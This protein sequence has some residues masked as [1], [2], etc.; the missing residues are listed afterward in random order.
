MMA[1]EVHVLI[2]DDEANTRGELALILG[3][4][5]YK[6]ETARTARTALEKARGRFFH[7]ALIESRLLDLIAPLQVMR[8]ETVVIVTA[9]NDSVETEVRALN[10]GATAVITKP[11]HKDQVLAII[12]KALEKQRLIME[13]RQLLA[14]VGPEQ[15]KR[16]ETADTLLASDERSRRLAEAAH[17]HMG[18][19]IEGSTFPIEVH[20]KANP[21]K[22]GFVRLTAV[23]DITERMQA[24]ARLRKLSRAVE[25]SPSAVL[26]YD[27]GGVIEYVNPRFV[28]MTGYLPEE[29]IGTHV[30]KLGDNTAEEKKIWETILA[31]GEWQGEILNRKKDGDSYWF[32]ASISSIRD[33]QGVI[34]HF[35]EVQ[36]DITERRKTEEAM[37]QRNRELSLLNRVIAAAASTLEPEAVLKTTCRELAKTFDVPQS[38]AA[39]LDETGTVLR[40]VAEY[41]AEDGPTSLGA[42]IP[43]AGN[44]ATQYVLEQKVP[45]AVADAQQDPRMAPVHELMRR[46]GVVSILLIPLIVGD[47]VAGTVGLDAME[48]REFT[49][50]EIDL[51][52]SAVTTAAQMLEKAQLLTA[53]KRNAKRLTDILGL[54][55]DLAMLRDESELLKTLV[56]RVAAFTES[57]TCTILLLDEF[58]NEAVLMAQAGLPEDTPPT[59]RISL[60]LPILSRSLET[61]EPII[62]SDID[63][64]APEM[65]AVLVHP[66]I[67]AFFAYPMVKEGRTVGFMTLSDLK[68]RTPSE[69][70][71][72]AFRLLSERAAAALE[73]V[74]L[75]T[76]LQQQNLDLNRLHLASGALFSGTMSGIETLAQEIVETIQREFEHSNCSL[77]I[78]FEEGTAELRRVAAVGP[79]AAQLS[80]WSFPL[81]GKGLIPAAVRA[82]AI[83]NV[84][85]VE[86]H[87]DYTQGWQ[88]TRSEL[89]IPLIIG[90]RVIGAIDL[91]SALPAN[92]DLADER[93]LADFAERAA[94]ALQTANF[95]VE[96]QRRTEELETLREASLQL[97]SSLDRQEVMTSIL[98]NAVHLATAKNAYVFLYDEQ[99]LSFGAAYWMDGEDRQ[100]VYTEPRSDGVTETVARTGKPLV[101]PDVNSHPLFKDWQWGGAIIGLPLIMGGQILGVMNVAFSNPRAIEE[102]ELRILDLL[103]AQAAI[104]LNNSRLFD[105]IRRRAEE[106]EAV[107][108]VSSALR[109]A[110]TQSD[111]VPIILDEVSDLLNAESIALTI[112]DVISGES[113]I[114]LS[115]GAWDDINTLG[116]CKGHSNSGQVLGSE[117][118]LSTYETTLDSPSGA[119]CVPLIAQEI[120]IGDLWIGRGEGITKRE[121]Q[122]VAAIADIAASAIQRTRLYEKTLRHAG[123]LERRV[124]ERTNALSVAN[125]ELT[126]ANRAKDEFL[127]NMSHELRTPLSN[128]LVRSD[129]LQKGIY[130]PLTDKQERSLYVIEESSR[131]LLQLINDILDVSK[132]EAGKLELDVHR[133][134]VIS[135]CESSL[136]FVKEMAAQ[137]GIQVHKDIQPLAVRADGRR[138]KQILVNLLSNAVKF[139]PEGG[140]IG[141]EVYG[142]ADMEMIQFAVWDT[143][144]GIASDDIARLFQPFSQLDGSLARKFEGTGLGLALVRRLTEMHNGSVS[145]ESEE[146]QGSRFTISLPW[147][148]ENQVNGREEL[149]S[150]KEENQGDKADPPLA[151]LL[152]PPVT[153]LLA[154]DN[155]DLINGLMDYLS[156]SGYQVNVARDGTEAVQQTKD[157]MPNL[158]LMD[159]QMP[160]LDGLEAIRQ[161]RTANSWNVPIIALTALAMPG[162]RERCLEAGASE[163]LSKPISL[164]K[165]TGRIEHYLENAGLEEV[166]NP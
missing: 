137:K 87:P 157:Q 129:M 9:A 48:P 6:F 101:I 132:I 131:H 53:E 31:K 139:T 61:G 42:E 105:E 163:Y 27:V 72:T 3:E 30:S 122:L 29:I 119:V 59:L 94:L 155:E 15:A 143:G 151:Q 2:V 154:E 23:S 100:E 130:G 14:K 93:L 36:E 67:R 91:Q 156:F 159:I 99:K 103:A 33:S 140:S 28:Q 121:I 12:R 166:K 77:L 65:R 51:A 124:A 49:N 118:P 161:I 34:T 90:D 120:T 96:S 158:I 8:P 123:E 25:N 133:F 88:L 71:I 4:K 83:L 75:L 116:I 113:F 115:R 114:E 19:R 76:Q 44:P 37:H 85:D 86:V 153:I 63:R 52:T 5:G 62:I 89:T 165:L 64:V 57:P 144:V 73:N 145:I 109:T 45:L 142:D 56:T 150:V 1:A 111:I 69:A 164:E 17:E 10:A 92:F 39:L 38:G 104:A 141:L 102:N 125:A 128:V 26:I 68:S 74:R 22:N 152:D 106:L 136:Q 148:P 60:A 162:D 97:T 82:G 21:Y 95:F 78:L 147:H 47:R 80:Q 70:E 117:Q 40:V 20:G 41:M 13:H 138:L 160:G 24:E 127:A 81:N 16:E 107:V 11:W 58:A 55:T 7:L 110:Q 46:R 18:L 108:K 43:V 35:V 66:E 84:P 126:Q 79:Y 54:S 149:I 146:G 98:R 112:R 134:S 50:E 135:I 32:S